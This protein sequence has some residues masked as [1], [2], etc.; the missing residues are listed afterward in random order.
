MIEREAVLE[1]LFDIEE[2]DFSEDLF[3]GPLSGQWFRLGAWTITARPDERGVEN[4]ILRQSF[5][6]TCDGFARIFE[7][8]EAVGNVIGHLGKPNTSIIQDADRK[9]YRYAPFHR[10]DFDFTPVSGEP[11]VFTHGAISGTRLFINPD[12][13]LF[14]GLEERAPA[15]GIWW[16]PSRGVDVL[17]QRV[18]EDNNLEIV[19]IRNDYLMKYLQARQMS[20]IVGHYRHLHLLNPSALAIERFVSGELTLGFPADGVKALFQNW[21]LRKDIFGSLP[22]LQ[23]RLHLW[24][25][26]KP[27]SV[28]VENPWSEQPPFDTY[29]FTLPTRVGAVAPARYGYVHREVGRSFEGAV[30]DFL[31]RV[32]FRQEVLTKY[33]GASGFEVADDG[34]VR[35]RHYWGLVRSTSR[36]GNE[37]VATAIGDFAEGV[38]LEEWPHWKQYAVPLPARR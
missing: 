3:V 8:L 12:L 37:L 28:D 34:S 15:S 19:E 38:P 30:G 14:L 10:F 20:L 33:E 4:V 16:D 2:L 13:W 31:N 22:F 9:E 36:L 5:L 18:I 29:T 25:E 11:V 21:D 7:R 27:P 6:L 24:F 23:R 17:R 1:H 32:F 35:C 26:V